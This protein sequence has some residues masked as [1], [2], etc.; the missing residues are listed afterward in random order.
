[1]GQRDLLL[2]LCE[3]VEAAFGHHM[4][5]AVAAAATAAAIAA[6][7]AP[8]QCGFQTPR[9][10]FRA[11]RACFHRC[12]PSHQLDESIFSC[13]MYLRECRAGGGPRG[14]SCNLLLVFH[15]AGLLHS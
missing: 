4:R 8:R 5:A 7:G 6:V 1:M 14:K 9:G 12:M 2:D 10:G 15:L 3:S 11:L 13:N